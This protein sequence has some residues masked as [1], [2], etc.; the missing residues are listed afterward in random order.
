MADHDKNNIQVFESSAKTAEPLCA[1][2]GSCGGCDLQHVSYNDQ[3]KLKM[4]WLAQII[5]R[6]PDLTVREIIPSPQEY[7]YRN[8]ITLHHDGKAYGFYRASSHD[9]VVIDKCV[10]A[11]ELINDHL[12]VLNRDV[13]SGPETFEL[14]EGEGSYFLQVNSSQN[15][16]LIDTVL[17]FCRLKKSQRVLELYCG[18]GNLSFPLSAISK[19]VTAIDGDSQAIEIANMKRREEKIKKVRFFATA[20]YDAVYEFS[21]K[22]EQFDTILCDPPRE[23]LRD[24]AKIL[25]RF[26]AEKIIYVSCNPLSFIRDAKIFSSKNYRLKEIVPIDMFP[27]TKHVEIVG[28]FCFKKP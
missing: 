10:I 28:L 22:L 26:K 25:P 21:Q 14:R 6:F 7:Y 18:S 3:L 13:L 9:I 15:Q 19:S 8:R 24:V 5:A 27:Q 12:A 16:N 1:Y 20:V 17:N 11:S 23:G 2:Y 4:K